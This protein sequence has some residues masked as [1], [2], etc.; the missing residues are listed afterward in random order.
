MTNKLA[1]ELCK[2]NRGIGGCPAHTDC[3]GCGHYN[4]Y[5]LLSNH[6]AANYTSREK[7]K[8]I[9]DG[10]SGLTKPQRYRHIC[11]A[12]SSIP[13]LNTMTDKEIYPCPHQGK[14]DWATMEIPKDE[15]KPCVKCD[16][17]HIGFLDDT[18]TGR[19]YNYAIRDSLVKCNE[20][21][22]KE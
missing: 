9:I 6:V 2:N 22:D 13:R 19:H 14:T 7:V 8:K 17:N 11:Y 21:I 18:D 12:G 15:E 4:Q 20:I 10:I 1:K 5:K 3:N 16:G